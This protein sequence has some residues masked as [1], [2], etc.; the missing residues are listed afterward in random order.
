MTEF[1]VTATLRPCPECK[2]TL[3]L[4]GGRIEGRVVFS[5]GALDRFITPHTPECTTKTEDHP[6]PEIKWSGTFTYAEQT[7]E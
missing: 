5:G 3:V 2:A 1:T 7:G 6:L 4:R